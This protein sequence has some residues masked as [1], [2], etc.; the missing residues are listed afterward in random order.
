MSSPSNYQLKL[1]VTVG[2]VKHQV[3]DE[4]GY[5]LDKELILAF[6]GKHLE[7]GASMLQCKIQKGDSFMVV[8]RAGESSTSFSN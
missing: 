3:N 8:Y 2:D 5:P 6:R 4:L 7:D 1:K